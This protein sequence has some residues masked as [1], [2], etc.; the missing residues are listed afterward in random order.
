M[1]SQCDQAIQYQKILLWTAFGSGLESLRNLGIDVPHLFNRQQ[2]EAV[3]VSSHLFSCLLMLSCNTMASNPSQPH[4]S[5][6]IAH[7]SR[8]A[9]STQQSMPSDRKDEDRPRVGHERTHSTPQ[10]QTSK[11]ATRRGV[12]SFTDISAEEDTDQIIVS[13][14]G[15][16]IS[17][18]RVSVAIG[19]R[20]WLG[21][22]PEMVL[23]NLGQNHRQNRHAVQQHTEVETD[24]ENDTG[25]GAN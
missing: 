8:V 20:Q 25:R 19:S 16:L 21:Q 11:T 18:E 22:I 3:A 2:S 9:F 17:A 14:T 10:T 6:K 1:R 7:H 4:A 13:T 15:D 24:F 12:N 23:Q 5:L